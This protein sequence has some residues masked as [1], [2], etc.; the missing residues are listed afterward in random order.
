MGQNRDDRT[1]EKPR[2]EPD[3]SNNAN[4]AIG[5]Q[6]ESGR[7]KKNAPTYVP[8]LH[9]IGMSMVSFGHFEWFQRPRRQTRLLLLIV[10]GRDFYVGKKTM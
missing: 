1:V 6:L 2:G 7:K 3:D 9:R 8:F 4:T 10:R 5:D